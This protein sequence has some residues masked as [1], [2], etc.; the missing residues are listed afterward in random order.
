M[1]TTEK[2]PLLPSYQ[3]DQTTSPPAEPEVDGL[4]QRVEET[5]QAWM[6]A[7]NAYTEAWKRTPSGRR[8]TRFQTFV[9]CITS[10]ICMMVIGS[11]FFVIIYTMIYGDEADVYKPP[12][13]VPLEAHVMSKCPDA[14]DCLNDL[15]LPAMMETSRM[16]DFKLSYIGTPTDSDD[17]IECKHGP[18]ECLGNILELCAAKLYP[19]PKMY[20]GF[21]MCMTRQYSEI[22]AQSLVQDCALEHGISFDQLNDCASDEHLGTGIDLL[23]T[24]VERSQSANVSTSCTVRLDN[25][26]W[27]VRHE[28]EWIDCPGGSD[29]QGLIAEIKKLRTE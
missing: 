14:R 3:D 28:G 18:T 2:A 9:I 4:R 10:A 7:A 17:G 6:D 12:R 23:R 16:V 25:K 19:D 29:V 13:K 15:I 8:V 21:T 24:S 26:V 27:C 11:V 22:P 20:L 1:A 5:R